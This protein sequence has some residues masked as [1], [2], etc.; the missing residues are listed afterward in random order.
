MVLLLGVFFIILFLSLIW[1]SFIFE[2]YNFKI[3]KIKIEIKNLPDSFDGIKIVQISDIHSKKFGRKEKAVLKIINELNPEYIFITGD[4]IDHKTKNLD[5][6]REF[7]QRLGNSY[8]N[9]IFAVFGNHLHQ[10]KFVNVHFFKKILQKDGIDILVNENRILKK[11]NDQIY[12]IGV[13]DS[14]T[15]HHDIE[16]AFDGVDDNSVKILLAH[17]PDIIEDIGV[18]KINI[19]F[20]GHTHGGQVKFPFIPAFWIPTKYHGK[21]NR[22]LYNVKNTLIYINRGIGTDILPIRFNSSPEITLIELKRKE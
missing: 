9:R 18:K 8:P 10:N 3:E 19:V 2:P 15:K 20:C 17:S 13:D 5:L 12:L 22:G 16:R 6:C 4:I 11:N 1:Y 21:Y 14:R 7:W